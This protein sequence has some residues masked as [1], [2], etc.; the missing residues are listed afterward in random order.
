MEGR[1]WL[2]LVQWVW[3]DFQ[4]SQPRLTPRY[5]GRQLLPRSSSPCKGWIWLSVRKSRALFEHPK[6][7]K[8]SIAGSCSLQPSRILGLSPRLRSPSLAYIQCTY[9]S[10]CHSSSLF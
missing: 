2:R 5:E 8:P 4:T 7:F 9:K 6:E 3:G 10:A 1:T